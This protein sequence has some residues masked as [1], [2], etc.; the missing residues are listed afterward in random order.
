MKKTSI[1]DI[2]QKLNVS[3]A[4][5]SRALN[6]KAGVS[7]E[8]KAKVMREVYN[9]KYMSNSA[10]RNLQGRINKNIGVFFPFLEENPILPDTMSKKI[11]GLAKVAEE[12]GYT[13]SLFLEKFKQDR[14][15]IWELIRQYDLC[16]LVMLSA[17]D[18]SVYKM[19]SHYEIP[20][21]S[22]NWYYRDID[23]GFHANRVCY[24]ETD[25]QS[26]ASQLV[27]HMLQ[28]GYSDIG[29]INWQ[30]TA[31]HNDIYSRTVQKLFARHHIA[32]DGFWNT[33][34]D[35]TKEDVY[36][37]LDAHPKRAYISML[38]KYGFWILEYCR[39]RGLRVPEDVA[40]AIYDY[41]PMFEFTTLP[42][43]T[44]ISQSTEKMGEKSMEVLI[45]MIE[46]RPFPENIKIKPIFVRGETT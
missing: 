45:D 38:Y 13:L 3:V 41:I 8:T 46:G 37:Y 10:A 24:V 36:A 9:M 19:V 12:K 33:D 7:E 23:I 14:N 6:N 32:G 25:W 27:E 44:G 42:H 1:V 21:V 28:Q 18:M 17:I 22:I 40:V 15:K 26:A 29:F 31:T 16:G 43:L 5:V 35:R 20:L 4:T 2:A 39:E 30:D 34:L 11:A